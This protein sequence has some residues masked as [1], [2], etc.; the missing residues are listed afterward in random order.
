MGVLK[1]TCLIRG[2]W[3]DD[4]GGFEDELAM[5]D[6]IEDEMVRA[7]ESQELGKLQRRP[8]NFPMLGQR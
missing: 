7:A 4:G 5:L 1:L 3:D 8:P 6:D 2:D